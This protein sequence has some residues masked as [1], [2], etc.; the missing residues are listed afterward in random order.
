MD[1]GRVFSNHLKEDIWVLLRII[2]D[3]ETNKIG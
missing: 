2:D 1:E 3:L